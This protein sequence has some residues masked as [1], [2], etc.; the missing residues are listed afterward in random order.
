M[1]LLGLALLS[2]MTSACCFGGTG[3]SWVTHRLDPYGISID[4]APGEVGGPAGAGY[5]FTSGDGSST[6]A[7]TPASPGGPAAS[8]TVHDFLPGAS[9]TVEWTR[10]FAYGDMTGTETRATES[11]PHARVHWI[12]AIDAPAGVVFIDL[13]TDQRFITGPTEGDRAWTTLRGSVRRAP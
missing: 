1:R 2:A 7:I 9:T 8:R 4:L 5:L 12:G 6:V 11:F 3:A 10:P 13:A